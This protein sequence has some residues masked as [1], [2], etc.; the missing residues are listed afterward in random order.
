M[1]IYSVL[2]P[3]VLIAGLEGRSQEFEEI[4]DGIKVQ[5]EPISEN[6]AIINRVLSTNPQDFLNPKLQPGRLISY[7]PN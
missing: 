5:V 3:E 4:I 6:A 7:I 1:L 2:P